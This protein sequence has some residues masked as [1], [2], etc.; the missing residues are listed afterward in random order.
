MPQALVVMI[1]TTGRSHLLPS[2]PLVRQ[3]V[4]RGHRVTRAIGD[5][6]ADLARA[7]D[8]DVMARPLML[9]R[10][11]DPAT[12]WPEEAVACITLCSTR[13]LAFSPPSSIASA[14]TYQMETCCCLPRHLTN[15][16]TGPHLMHGAP[17]VDGKIETHL[18]VTR[19]D[20]LMTEPGSIAQIGPNPGANSKKPLKY[21]HLT[22]SVES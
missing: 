22:R 3:L 1:A 15:L 14:K 4:R 2:M 17:Y 20:N 5:S 19:H 8:A 18:V 12:A 10:G 11:N 6:L 9:P 21:H 13:V 16:R 7:Y